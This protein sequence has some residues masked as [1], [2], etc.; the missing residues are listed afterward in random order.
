MKTLKGTPKQFDSGCEIQIWKDVFFLFFSSSLIPLSHATKKMDIFSILFVA[1]SHCNKDLFCLS[2]WFTA[3]NRFFICCTESL[4]QTKFVYV[5]KKVPKMD[6]NTAL[7]VMFALYL[8][9]V[10]LFG[11]FCAFFVFCIKIF[12]HILAFFFCNIY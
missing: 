4:I 10:C 2:H 6:E 12:W 1:L 3:T 7:I 5:A 11:T 8:R 9:F